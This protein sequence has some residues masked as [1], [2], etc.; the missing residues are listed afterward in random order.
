MAGMRSPLDQTRTLALLALILAACSRRSLIAQPR[1]TATVVAS[2]PSAATASPT[3]APS[4]TSGCTETQAILLHQAYPSQGLND[5]IAIAAVLPPCYPQEGVQYPA[6]YL[7]H[8]KPYDQN[9][10]LSL[11]LVEALEDSWQE[12]GPGVVVLLP[13][14]PEPLFS[15]SDGGPGSYEQEFM[16]AVLPYAETRFQISRSAKDRILAGISRGGVWALEIG[17][18]HPEKF[19]LVAGI[20]PA[21]SVNYPRAE[22]D[23]FQLA[24]ADSHLPAQIYLFAGETDWARPET[25]RLAGLLRGRGAQVQLHIASGDHSD[26]TW[27]SEIDLILGVLLDPLD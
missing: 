16:E 11:G 13:H 5:A 25:E 27:A 18:R 4:P 9:H 6:L 1:P 14:A 22:Y 20:S 24:I 2:T 10:W 8:G 12:P 21:L 23:P 19:G 3:V 26:A 7:L 17:F 15:R